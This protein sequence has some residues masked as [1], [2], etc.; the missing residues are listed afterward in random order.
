MLKQKLDKR[1]DYIV[2]QNCNHQQ[3]IQDNRLVSSQLREQ[4]KEDCKNK[5]EMIERQYHS[6]IEAVKN[7][8]S[9]RIAVIK[10]QCAETLKSTRIRCVKLTSLFKNALETEKKRIQW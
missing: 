1:D 6:K 4:Q 10:S 8:C 3:K 5:I 7:N 2:E 9:K